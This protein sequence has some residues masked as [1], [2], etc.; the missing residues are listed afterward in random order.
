MKKSKDNPRNGSKRKLTPE[1]QESAAL[2]GPTQPKRPMNKSAAPSTPFSFS[3]NADDANTESEKS[4]PNRMDRLFT[5]L[6]LLRSENSKKLTDLEKQ[7]L[8]YR[9]ENNE[10]MLAL[11]ED[12]KRI[13]V[14][15]NTKWQET[16]EKVAQLEA[17]VN[18]IQFGEHSKELEDRL[19]LIEDTPRARREDNDAGGAE[20]RVQQ[21]EDLVDSQERTLKKQNVVVGGLITGDTDTADN[22]A[23]ADNV[24]A[25]APAEAFFREKFHLE[26]GIE[27]VERLGATG[28]LIRVKFATAGIKEHIMK[29]KSSILRGTKFSIR[30]DMTTRDL[31]ISRALRERAKA[32]QARGKTTK[33]IGTRIAIDNKWMRWDSAANGS[34]LP[35][36]KTSPKKNP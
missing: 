8:A 26:Q 3:D 17:R 12:L 13:E 31:R 20:G 16:T 23:P 10:G 30:N 25:L 7:L 24:G 18:D 36:Q 21:L 34:N 35:T 29:V 22:T 6:Q 28:A 32:E 15:T 33:V 9:K 4:E 14:A 27:E 1:P 5:E 11:R 19:S 2:S